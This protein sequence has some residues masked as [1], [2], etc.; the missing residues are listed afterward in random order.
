MSTHVLNHVTT[1]SMIRKTRLLG[2]RA[3]PLKHGGAGDYRADLQ[4]VRQ[5]QN[6]RRHLL[7][8]KPGKWD[9]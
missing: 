7:I 3:S 6:G 9:R 1:R 4:Q 8:T 5:I 2:R